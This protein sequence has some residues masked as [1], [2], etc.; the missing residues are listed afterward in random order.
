MKLFYLFLILAL[1]CRL[2]QSEKKYKLLCK[3]VERKMKQERNL[4]ATII[5]KIVEKAGI[6]TYTHHFFKEM[7]GGINNIQMAK[8]NPFLVINRYPETQYY[9]DEGQQDIS[10]PRAVPEPINVYI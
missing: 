10:L 6:H 7:W 4:F 2:S 3:K 8:E 1:E 9:L 5:K